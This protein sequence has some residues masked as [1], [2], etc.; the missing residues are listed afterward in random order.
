MMDS[1]PLPRSELSSG[2]LGYFDTPSVVM[3]NMGKAPMSGNSDPALWPLSDD[4]TDLLVLMRCPKIH[5]L[6]GTPIKRSEGML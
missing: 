1:V 2:T 6:D 5:R 4:P 3:G